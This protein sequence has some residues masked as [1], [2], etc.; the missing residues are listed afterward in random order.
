[1]NESIKDN[2]F[3][4]DA[5]TQS[6]RNDNKLIVNPFTKKQSPISITQEG[7]ELAEKL[8]MEGMVHSNWDRISYYTEENLASNNPY[9][10]Q[11]FFMDKVC[12]FPDKFITH[13]ELDKIKRVAY[14][15][16]YPLFSYLT[17]IAILIRDKYFSEHNIDV[18]EI[19]VHTPQPIK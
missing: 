7:Y 14:N 17:V 15:D 4:L 6:L 18:R 3:K 5:L 8:N 19:D 10:I 12:V 11:Q 2:A 1:M 9:D 16:G 13:E